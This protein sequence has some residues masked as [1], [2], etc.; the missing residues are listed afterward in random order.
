MPEDLY[1]YGKYAGWASVGCKLV[2][3]LKYAFSTVNPYGFQ[4]WVEFMPALILFILD[5]MKY[6]AGMDLSEM[7]IEDLWYNILY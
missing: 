5:M 1:T 7:G 2:Y 4:A 3:L 6:V